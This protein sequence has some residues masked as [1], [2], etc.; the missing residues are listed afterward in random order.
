MEK[1]F[2][3]IVVFT[4]AATAAYI[5]MMTM[6]G[7]LMPPASRKNLVYTYGGNGFENLR[8]REAKANKNIDIL[9]IG[10]SRA[11][12]SFDTRIFEDAGYNCFNLGSSNQTPVQSLAILEKH[13]PGIL[14]KTVVM[15]VN[16]DIFSNDGIESAI[17]LVSN[18]PSL[19]EMFAYSKCGINDIRIV[20]TLI[21]SMATKLAGRE[22]RFARPVKGQKYIPGGFVQT[23]EKPYDKSAG[24]DY[25]C[26]IKSR[27]LEALDKITRLMQRNNIRLWLVQS[28]VVPALYNSCGQNVYFDSLMTGKARY[29][30]FNVQGKFTDTIHFS[31]GQH[32][33]EEGV[34]NLCSWML[35][36]L[37]QNPK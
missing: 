14:P 36:I 19:P 30:N 35:N 34:K 4:V 1:F 18:A 12:R 22:E 2:K 7:W 6:A 5:L 13:L 28:P 37:N 33:N 3:N 32:L 11:Y 16:P 9:F 23:Q 26:D 29:T 25:H 17:D 10:S 8:L 27:Q 20:N 15:E 24:N 31:D 21:F